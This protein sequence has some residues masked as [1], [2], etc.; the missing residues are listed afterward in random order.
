MSFSVIGQHNELKSKS[1]LII[2]GV[3][4][5][6]KRGGGGGGGRGGGKADMDNLFCDDD[7]QKILNKI[8]L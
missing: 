1:L 8:E 4:F 7:K 6:D 3:D 5:D 2:E